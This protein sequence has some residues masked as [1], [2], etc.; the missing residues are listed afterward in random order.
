[1]S[2]LVV[3]LGVL[4]ELCWSQIDRS[5]IAFFYVGS[6]YMCAVC[7]RHEVC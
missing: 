6:A 7:L 5:T 4:C 2:P 1:M 3:L